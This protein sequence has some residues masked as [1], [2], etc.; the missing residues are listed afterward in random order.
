MSSLVVTTLMDPRCIAQEPRTTGASRP[1]DRKGRELG[2]RISLAGLVENGF[3]LILVSQSLPR[4]LTAKDRSKQTNSLQFQVWIPLQRAPQTERPET[5]GDRTWPLDV[6]F[7]VKVCRH[8]F[9]CDASL[10]LLLK[11][12][13]PNN[14]VVHKP[15]PYLRILEDCVYVLLPGPVRVH[16]VHGN[17]GSPV[18]GGLDR[19]QRF[20]N[21]IVPRNLHVC[22][23]LISLRRSSDGRNR[24]STSSRLN[25]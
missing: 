16:P 15:V 17:H 11:D 2:P 9:F 24:T 22:R 20:S 8:D 23:T 1:T 12:A 13:N 21:F 6:M 10:G 25:R 19:F 5:M 7:L 4:K 14:P 3:D 18:T